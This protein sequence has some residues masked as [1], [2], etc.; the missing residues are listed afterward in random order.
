MKK[1]L[2]IQTLWVLTKIIDKLY[3]HRL[4]AHDI[5]FGNSSYGEPQITITTTVTELHHR[6]AIIQLSDRFIWGVRSIL[7]CYNLRP[8]KL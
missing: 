5:R 4:L 8:Y 7:F 1:K 3:S 2:R 6:D